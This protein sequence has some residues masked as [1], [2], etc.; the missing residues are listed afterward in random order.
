MLLATTVIERMAMR[1]SR[2]KTGKADTVVAEVER[3]VYVSQEHVPNDP[4][5]CHL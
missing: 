5:S 4:E 3:R 1:L 2:R